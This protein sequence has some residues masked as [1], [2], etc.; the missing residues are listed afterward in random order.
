MFT[1]Q[2]KFKFQTLWVNK[3]KNMLK[4]ELRQRFVLIYFTYS[5]PVD[6]ML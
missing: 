6:G 5:C 1:I 3:Y 2:M 4:K